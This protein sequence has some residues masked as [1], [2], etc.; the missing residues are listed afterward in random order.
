MLN[1]SLAM[2]AVL[3]STAVDYTGAVRRLET[4]VGE[5]MN[6]HGIRAVAVALIDDHQT[7]H[8]AGYGAAKRDSI[9]RCGSISKLFNAV[10]VMQLVEQGKLDLDAPIDRY[11]S[12]LSI[13]VPFE[14]A[15]PITLRQLL[16]HRSGMVRESPVGGYLDPSQPTLA[17]TVASVRSCVLVNPP[18]TKT[19]YSNVGPT[20]AGQAVATVAGMAY[21]QYQKDRVLGPLGMDSSSFV[22][23]DV[24]RHRMM[25]GFMR[26]A[27]GRGGFTHA[28]APLFDLGTIPAGNL[29]TPADDLARF[30]S[31][32]ASEGRAGDR[33]IVSAASLAAMCTPQL[34][35]GDMGF[36][37]GFRVGKFRT[38]K[39]VAHMGAV[40]GHTSSLAFLPGPKIGV[41]VLSNEDIAT[42]P[43]KKITDLALSLM[44]EAK[45]GEKPPQAPA[46]TML[47]PDALAPLVG[48]YESASSW[49]TIEAAGAQLVG[50]ISGQPIALTPIGPLDFLAD[51]R[52]YDAVRTTFQRNASGR[53]TGFSL[54]EQKFTR[55][56]PAGTPQTPPLWAQYSG[57][58]GPDF[59]P[60]VVSVRHGH[61]YA[62]T[63]N[64]QDY[65]LT[66]INRNVFALPPGMYADEH[67]V[68]LTGPDGNVHAVNMANMLL[69]R[70]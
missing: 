40:Y 38:H 1:G 63:E 52:I 48:Q 25:P 23:K 67:L 59:I 13:V 31:M 9:F 14:G 55:V 37:L 4:A 42:G 24:P 54:G 15:G 18:N 49:A 26:I 33:Q 61:L 50:N 53:V 45:L 7:V 16:C 39:L 2:V 70:R 28:Q 46:P 10:A 62:M 44:L 35:E 64:E 66:P 5:Q 60:L 43:I 21:E 56:D 6:Q 12:R 41:V 36:G 20:L 51:G 17:E 32:L 57:S 8:A 22:L 47:A 19:R 30:V 65:R 11:D 29:F 27:D 3:V 58:Y 69:R 34:V 68:F